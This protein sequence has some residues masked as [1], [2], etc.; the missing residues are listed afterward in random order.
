MK[1][2]KDGWI[3]HRGGKCPV[4]VGELVDVRMRCKH[5]E[6]A[7]D[8]FD[9]RWEHDGHPE[10][11]MQ[12]RPHKAEQATTEQSSDVEMPAAK[13]FDGPLQWRDRVQEINRQMADLRAEKAGLIIKLSEEG[14]TLIG[15]QPF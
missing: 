7:V 14:F 10:E 1:A 11:V 3:R 2:N 13:Y 6:I 9:L 12:W 15:E 4:D 5:E 8:A